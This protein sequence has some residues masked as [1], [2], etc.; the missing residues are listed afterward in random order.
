M[1]CCEAGPFVAPAAML[2]RCGGGRGRISEQVRVRPYRVSSVGSTVGHLS[3]YLDARLR[4][5]PNAQLISTSDEPASHAPHHA[6]QHAYTAI[7]HA[8]TWT[9]LTAAA[10]VH[11]QRLHA[12]VGP[13]QDEAWLGLGFRVRMRPATGAEVHAGAKT[14]LQPLAAHKV[15]RPMSP[16]RRR[17]VGRGLGPRVGVGV[18][19]GL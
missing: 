17:R 13:H 3:T 16:L 15:Q 9:Y 6:H 2:G 5:P 19:V 11:Q 14:A 12:S 7:Y 10:G 8:H 1:S 18:G 4:S